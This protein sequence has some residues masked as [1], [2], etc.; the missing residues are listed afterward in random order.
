M[1]PKTTIDLSPLSKHIEKICE[2]YHKEKS[3]EI[4]LRLLS[5]MKDSQASKIL[6]FSRQH[7]HMIRKEHNIPIPN[8]KENKANQYRQIISNNYSQIEGLL[9][10]IKDAE[11]ARLFKV[12]VQYIRPLRLEKGIPKYTIPKS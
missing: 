12:P 9:G 6:G 7:C 8:K 11:I 4:T 1:K 10:K 3:L 5:V 2:D